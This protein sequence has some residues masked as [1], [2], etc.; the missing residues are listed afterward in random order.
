MAEIH[1][2][3]RVDA[4]SLSQVFKGRPR[5][6]V[7]S[8][9][10]RVSLA[11]SVAPVVEDEL[12]H[13]QEVMGPGQLANSRT[14]VAPVAVEPQPRLRVGAYDARRAREEPSLKLQ[15]VRR[16]EQYVFVGQALKFRRGVDPGLRREDETLF[17]PPPQHIQRNIGL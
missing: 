5:I 12:V 1:D 15:A 10:R 11:V 17:G 8:V 3:V 7:G 14:Q 2:A 16:C 4:R 9:L 6:K 13:S